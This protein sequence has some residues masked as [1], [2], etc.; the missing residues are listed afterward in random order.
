MITSSLWGRMRKADT[1]VPGAALMKVPTA[2]YNPTRALTIDTA[3]APTRSAPPSP[4]EGCGSGSPLT[5]LALPGFAPVL[6]NMHRV[7]NGSSD[8]KY[9]AHRR[10]Y[11][12]AP[13]GLPHKNGELLG[14]SDT[15][16]VLVRL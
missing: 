9:P 16:A 8:D 7:G 11:A 1:V 14:T 10:P 2:E 12:G 13:A 5:V 4:R 15:A 3:E 6:Y